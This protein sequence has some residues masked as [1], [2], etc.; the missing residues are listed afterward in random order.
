MGAVW[1][2]DFCGLAGVTWFET[3]PFMR[4]IPA[5][6][7]GRIHSISYGR[8]AWAACFC[9]AGSIR[10]G[11]W[12]IVTARSFTAQNLAS[13]PWFNPEDALRWTADLHLHVADALTGISAAMLLPDGAS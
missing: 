10:D 3:R 9:C 8:N 12:D 4:R 7:N 13:G 1:P 11:R 2:C 6:S 5:G